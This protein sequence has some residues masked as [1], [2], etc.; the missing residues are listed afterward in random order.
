MKGNLRKGKREI[1]FK[2]TLGNRSYQRFA[3]AHTKICKFPTK[4]QI[5]N[6]CNELWTK[7]KDVK[8]QKEFENKYDAKMIEFQELYAKKSNTGLFRTFKK[9][10]L[11]GSLKQSSLTGF[12]NS[13]NKNNGNNDNTNSNDISIRT[14]DDKKRNMNGINN[15]KIKQNKNNDNKNGS[16][17]T[18]D[19]ILMRG[20]H[21]TNE[22]ITKNDSRDCPSQKI[23][24]DNINNYRRLIELKQ[25]ELQLP[26]AKYQQL[27]DEIQDL[28]KK[29]KQSEKKLKRLK[30]NQKSQ[31]KLRKDQRRLMKKAKA[32]L[33]PE[34]TKDITIKDGP[35]QP[36]YI[37]TYAGRGFVP[38]LKAL[39]DE[40]AVADPTR[41]SAITVSFCCIATIL[42]FCGIVLLCNCDNYDSVFVYWWNCFGV[43]LY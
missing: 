18:N 24:Q 6:E 29:K 17:D 10:S 2:P 7:I 12:F 43:S 4:A 28:K 30:S 16:N 19:D 20:T 31:A 35:G 9:S 23:E 5:Q 32:K 39:I 3:N 26:G 37:D 11:T 14:N 8:S 21:D 27:K 36:R 15:D 1:K 25:Q 13:N 41:R 42:L 38:F 40:F 33:P 34:D 22:V